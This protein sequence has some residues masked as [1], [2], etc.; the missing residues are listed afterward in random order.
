MGDGG[1]FSSSRQAAGSTAVGKLLIPF[2]GLV[3]SLMV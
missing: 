1:P 3:N 2:L